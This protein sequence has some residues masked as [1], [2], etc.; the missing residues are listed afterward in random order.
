MIARAHFGNFPAFIIP[1]YA[2]TSR[3]DIVAILLLEAVNYVEHYGLTRKHLG[4]GRYE[5]TEARHSWNASH[6]VTN[7]FLINLQRHSDHHYKPARRFPLLQT[8]AEDDAPQLPHGYPVM[9]CA[10][11]IPPLWFRMMNR[12]VKDWRGRFYPEIEDWT[13][14][15]KGLTPVD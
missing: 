8:Y 14:Y 2:F 15:R 11:L 3:W 7:L 10:S 4:G 13:P 12:R 9:V 5:R 1:E 6:L